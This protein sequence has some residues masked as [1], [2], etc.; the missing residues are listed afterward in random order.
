MNKARIL[1]SLGILCLIL[2]L[3]AWF[4]AATFPRVN[5]LHTCNDPTALQKLAQYDRDY[6]KQHPYSTNQKP[7]PRWEYL[8][9][10]A[11]VF[12]SPRLPSILLGSGHVVWGTVTQI[13]DDGCITVKIKRNVIG[14]FGL[15]NTVEVND[16]TPTLEVGKEYILFLNFDSFKKAYMT[17]CIEHGIFAVTPEGLYAYSNSTDLSAYDGQSPRA[18]IDQLRR[19]YSEMMDLIK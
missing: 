5:P 3:L 11:S 10:T 1:K 8:T 4:Y 18:L 19:T 15:N 14:H 7:C 6:I 2:C 9:R 16:V 13:A 12:Y 17:T